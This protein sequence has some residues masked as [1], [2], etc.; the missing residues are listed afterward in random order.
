MI[1]AGSNDGVYWD[2]GSSATLGTSTSFVGNI[3]AQQSVTM[4]TTAKDGCGRIFALNAA[5][6]MDTNVISNTCPIVN[7][8]T[9]L[10]ERSAAALQ[11]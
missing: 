4:T 1:N 6:T 10:S 3:I 7:G 9:T 5:V 11:L 8:G 2:V